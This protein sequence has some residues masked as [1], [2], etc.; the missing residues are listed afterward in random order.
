MPPTTLFV[1]AKFPRQLYQT[2]ILLLR[3]LQQEAR[4]L[5]ADFKVDMDLNNQLV[6]GEFRSAISSSI[7]LGKIEWKQ[8]IPHYSYDIKCTGV[9]RSEQSYMFRFTSES[10]SERIL[11][12]I[13]EQNTTFLAGSYTKWYGYVELKCSK[14]LPD[15]LFKR[16]NLRIEQ[17]NPVSYINHSDLIIQ[18]SDDE[19]AGYVFNS[20]QQ[21]LFSFKD[22]PFLQLI[23]KEDYKSQRQ[24]LLEARVSGRERVRVEGNSDVDVDINII[25]L[26]AREERSRL[27][28]LKKQ[29]DNISKEISDIVI[30][31]AAGDTEMFKCPMCDHRST[32]AELT[33]HVNEHLDEDQNTVDQTVRRALAGIVPS[34]ATMSRS[35]ILRSLIQAAQTAGVSTRYGDERR[36]SRVGVRLESD[37]DSEEDILHD[38]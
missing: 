15:Y 16:I 19:S 38:T 23:K 17:I 8:L 14:S 26:T 2:V 27:G 11:E 9:T 20:G 32:V 24:L 33:R 21:Y 10:L 13:E 29:L 35:E 7:A 30:D 4:M 5:D 3:D 28:A 12:T 18:R 25:P 36:P 22:S 6:L 37:Q 31:Y 1:L 34:M